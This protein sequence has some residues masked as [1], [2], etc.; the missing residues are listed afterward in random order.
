VRRRLALDRLYAV[1]SH[2][3]IV[4]ARASVPTLRGLD[5]A[6]EEGGAQQQRGGFELQRGI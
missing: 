5:A 1:H 4:C 2:H 6:L 3:L